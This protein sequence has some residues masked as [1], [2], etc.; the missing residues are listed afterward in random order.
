M[1]RR[2]TGLMLTAAVVGGFSLGCM[3]HKMDIE[4]MKKMVSERPKELDH[5]EMYV[6]TWEVTG[7]GTMMGEEKPVTFKG[8]TTINWEAEKEVLF[9]RSTFEMTDWPKMSSIGVWVYD[10]AEGHFKNYW[11]SNYGDIGEGESWYDKDAKTWHTK[12]KSTHAHSEGTTTFKDASTMEWTWV[13]KTPLGA[14]TGEFK[15]TSK[16]K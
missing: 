7:T 12:G 15:G 16:K 5:L 3:Q 1:M 2:F 11:F 9:E 14:K 13:E 8:T 6:G 10:A 4:T